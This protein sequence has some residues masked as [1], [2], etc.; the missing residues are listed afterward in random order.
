[1]V[2]PTWSSTTGGIDY[3]HVL[4]FDHLAFVVKGRDSSSP[5]PAGGYKFAGNETLKDVNVTFADTLPDKSQEVELTTSMAKTAIAG[6]PLHGKVI[7]KNNGSAMIPAQALYVSSKTLTPSD[8]MYTVDAI[9]PFGKATIDV[10]FHGMPF[11]T[12]TSSQF[13]IRLAEETSTHKIKVV[14]FFLT[15]LGIGGILFG[16]LATFICIITFKVRRLRLFR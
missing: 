8:Q 15:P 16:I 7:I 2:D 1:M 13:T 6:L 14:P 10:A 9:P 12:N 11:L 3:F 4:D 5:I